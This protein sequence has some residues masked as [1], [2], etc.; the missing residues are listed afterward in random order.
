MGRGN[1]TRQ[2]RTEAEGARQKTRRD[3][4]Q[5]TAGKPDKQ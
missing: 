5:V 4:G 1:A 3:T 2:D